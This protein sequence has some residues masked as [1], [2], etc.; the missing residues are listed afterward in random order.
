MRDRRRIVG[1]M[2]VLTVLGFLLL[3]PPLVHL[4]NHD[5]RIGG[6]PQIVVYLFVVWGGLIVGIMTLTRWLEPDPA[7]THDEDES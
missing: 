6:V 2:L 5:G 3:M 1:G 4:F 7:G